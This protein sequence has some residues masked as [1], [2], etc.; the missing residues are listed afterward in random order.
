MPPKITSKNDIVFIEK[1]LAQKENAHGIE[2][3]HFKLA[4]LI[5]TT[6]AVLNLSEILRGHTRLVALCFGGDDFLGDLHGSY[7]DPPVAHFAPRAMVAMAARSAGLVPIDTPY[8]FLHDIEG[9]KKEKDQGFELGFG[10]SLLISPRHIDVINESFTPSREQAEQAK[11]IMDAIKISQRGGV[12]SNCVMLGERMVGPPMQ[13]RAEWI[14]ELMEL[15]ES[16][17]RR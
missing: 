11:A 7:G 14:M 3:G 5:E 2:Q 8:L 1:L 13:R 10:G 15:I 12:F 16:K 17:G 4:P 9:L 6:G